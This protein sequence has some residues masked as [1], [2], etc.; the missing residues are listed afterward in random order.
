MVSTMSRRTSSQNLADL[1]F[2]LVSACQSKER[3][4][5]KQFGISQSEFRILRAFRKAP[6]RHIKEITTELDLRASSFSKLA[7]G[8]EQ[9]GLLV[10]SIEPAD[11]RAVAVSLTARGSMLVREIEE[12]YIQIHA[13]LLS[14]IPVDMHASFIQLLQ[15]LLNSIDLWLQRSRSETS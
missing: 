3:V 13:D 1:T 10:R 6:Q 4:A 12:R 8:L 9:K 2:R 5:A 14:Q 15:T 7:A 11:R